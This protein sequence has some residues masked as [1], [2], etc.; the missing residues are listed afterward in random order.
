MQKAK[1]LNNVFICISKI[2]IRSIK[3]CSGVLRCQ[4]RNWWHLYRERPLAAL[5]IPTFLILILGIT[6]R[7][8][9]S[10][11]VLVISSFEVPLMTSD[12]IGVTGNT[13]AN[14]FTEEIKR[15]EKEVTSIK[16]LKN[17][18]L[19]HYIEYDK[20]VAQSQENLNVNVGI[21]VGGLSWDRLNFE[22]Q[23]IRNKFFRVKGDV[24]IDGDGL[25]MYTSLPNY[26]SW[27]AGPYPVTSKGIKE[28][29]RELALMLL[30]EYKPNL[31]GLYYQLNG[32]ETKSI[33]IFHSWSEREPENHQPYFH[34]GEAY[35]YFGHFNKAISYLSKAIQ[36][37]EDF[38]EAWNN[39][40]IAY[41]DN[42]DHENAIQAYNNALEYNPNYVEALINLGDILAEQNNEQAIEVYQRA[43]KFTP[44]K[45]LVLIKLGE[46]YLL[47]D[48]YEEALVAFESANAHA[49]DDSYIRLKIGNLRLL[50]GQSELAD[51]LFHLSLDNEPSSGN[52]I[53]NVGRKELRFGNPGV[54][55]TLLLRKYFIISYRFEWKL[56]EWIIYDLSIEDLK[57]SSS[58]SDDFRVDSDIPIDKRA[59]LNDYRGSGFDRGQ[60]ASPSDFT[61]S[62]IAM[63]ETF[64]LSNICPQVPSLNRGNWAKL[65]QAVR[66]WVDQR[67]VLTIITGSGVDADK[68]GTTIGSNQVMVP[69]FFYKIVIDSNHPYNLQTLAF[70]MPN[71]NLKNADYSY[72]L[73]SIDDIES[74]TGLDFFSSLTIEEQDKIESQA[75]RKAW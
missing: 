2:G 33:D 19:S 50:M 34:L 4:A 6:L 60:L 73:T 15:I 44:D 67:G 42:K 1:R 26:G 51:S 55:D 68:Q 54:K 30:S 53:S 29:T 14:L 3:F 40:G 13:I 47:L 41:Y 38:Y 63:S 49:V 17:R 37:K 18:H 22:W 69:D 28:A 64:L 61:R 65:E 39:L 11:S 31:A 56:P 23:R 45:K 43:L 66:I 52:S 35:W 74:A 75:S 5:L 36:V 12:L 57:G 58:R 20:I 9:K 72:F 70:M 16:G 8:I 71:K 27:E 32:E 48:K 62:R 7:S 46:A 24:I 10:Q 21:D 59:E 25:M